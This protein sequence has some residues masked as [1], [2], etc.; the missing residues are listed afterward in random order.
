LQNE[1]PFMHFS[2][3]DIKDIEDEKETIVNAGWWIH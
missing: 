3:S 2:I 1:K